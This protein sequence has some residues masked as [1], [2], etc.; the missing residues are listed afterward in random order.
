MV[1]SDHGRQS[2]TA[3]AIHGL[4]LVGLLI[5]LVCIMPVIANLIF[6]SWWLV[7]SMTDLFASRE[8]YEWV[9]KNLG[10]L[11][12]I[13]I[14]AILAVTHAVLSRLRRRFTSSIQ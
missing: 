9:S 2:D 6:V 7:A 4:V 11:S 5:G 1:D 12:F 3:Q 13:A 10:M 8:S 14:I